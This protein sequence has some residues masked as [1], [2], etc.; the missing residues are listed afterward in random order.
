MPRRS[1][2]LVLV[3]VSLL[4]LAACG[5][6][7]VGDRPVSAAANAAAENA[8]A[9]IDDL[10]A[11]DDVRTHEVLDVTTGEP[12]SIAAVATGDRPLLLWFWAPH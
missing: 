6:D 3:V 1:P 10:V 5:S 12:T 7:G 2:V 9:T 4:V 8:A 11:T